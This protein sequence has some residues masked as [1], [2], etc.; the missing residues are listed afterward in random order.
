MI[1]LYDNIRLSSGSSDTLPPMPMYEF[2]LQP[3]IQALELM[4][5]SLESYLN[6]LNMR[7]LKISIDDEQ[8]LIEDEDIRDSVLDSIS[9]TSSSLMESTKVVLQSRLSSSSDERKTLASSSPPPE[10]SSNPEDSTQDSRCLLTSVDE[11]N[12][13]S[14]SVSIVNPPIDRQTSDEGYRSVQNEQQQQLTSISN[15]NSPLMIRS[16][17]YDCTDKVGTWLSNTT[18]S[19]LP[20]SPTF[21]VGEFQQMRK[22]NINHFRVFFS[23]LISM[24][25]EEFR[26]LMINKMLFD[27][28]HLSQTHSDV[29]FGDS[30]FSCLFVTLL[31]SLSLPFDFLYFHNIRCVGL[32]V[33]KNLIDCCFLLLND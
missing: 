28:D 27:F 29:L 11:L 21:Q 6:E 10:H 8:Q 26:C 12:G 13:H 25:M 31:R 17:S 14:Q 2:D 16:K 22:S 24:T 3:T 18:P 32:T 15:Q 5:Q 4:K 1:Q 23:Q 20:K 9:E 33:S 19:S 30:F 7:T